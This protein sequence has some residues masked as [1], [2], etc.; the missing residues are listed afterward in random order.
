MTD[1]YQPWSPVTQKQTFY[2]I[3]AVILLID[4]IPRKENEKQIAAYKNVYI[5][6]YVTYIYEE[7][8]LAPVLVITPK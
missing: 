7:I 6:T 3:I 8:P 2:Q 5:Y 1:K 4:L